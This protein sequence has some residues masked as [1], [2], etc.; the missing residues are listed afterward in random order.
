[1]YPESGSTYDICPCCGFQSG[2]D[3]IGWDRA[4]RN[5][6]LRRRWIESG[7]NWWSSARAPESNWNALEQLQAAGLDD[8]DDDCET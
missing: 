8:D 4:E 5:R 3:G 2:V 6:T 7:A 1:M